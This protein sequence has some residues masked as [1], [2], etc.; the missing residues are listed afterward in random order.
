MSYCVQLPSARQNPA[1]VARC[2]SFGQLYLY[3]VCLFLPLWMF[4]VTLLDAFG[5]LK[6]VAGP[7]LFRY[8]QLVRTD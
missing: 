2:E 4:Q 7:P 8:K 1:I 3:L 5:L 6:E